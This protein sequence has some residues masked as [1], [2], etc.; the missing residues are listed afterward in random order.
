HSP[1]SVPKL[2]PVHPRAPHFSTAKRCTI[3]AP[4]T[5]VRLLLARGFSRVGFFA[6]CKALL[7]ETFGAEHTDLAKQ[8]HDALVL[9]TFGAKEEAYQEL[10]DVAQHH[11]E[12]PTVCLIL[13][14]LWERIG[15]LDKVEQLWKLAARR[16]SNA[17]HIKHSIK[18]QFEDLRRGSPGGTSE[19]VASTGSHSPDSNTAT[20]IGQDGKSSAIEDKGDRRPQLPE[21][22]HE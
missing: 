4:F 5:P 8:L 18:V 3:Q 17:P 2:N 21:T 12:L 7:V 16:A 14:D 10:V 6:E 20:H 22:A 19:V 11:P 15:R 13:G 1:S 9:P